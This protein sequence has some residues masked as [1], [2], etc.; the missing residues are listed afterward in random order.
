M[1][2]RKPVNP[3]SVELKKLKREPVPTFFTLLVDQ[4]KPNSQPELKFVADNSFADC[5]CSC[6]AALQ[7]F[8]PEKEVISDTVF[9]VSIMCSTRA[10]VKRAVNAYEEIF[11]LEPPTQ[12]TDRQKPLSC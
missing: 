6:E 4:D 12:T 10:A 2:P 7:R 1:S 5:E 3:V 9:A 11:K 8:N